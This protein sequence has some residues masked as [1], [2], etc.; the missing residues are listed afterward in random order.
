MK[1][2]TFFLSIIFYS[3]PA[4]A[5]LD[6]GSGS[7]IAQALIFILASVGTFFTFFK[8]KIK[9]IYSKI[10]KKKNNINKRT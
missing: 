1:N 2:I 4:L 3:T 10:F 8:S 9:S 6:P 5:Y 7:I